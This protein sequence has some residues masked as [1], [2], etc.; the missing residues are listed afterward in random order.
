MRQPGLALASILLNRMG[1]ASQQEVSMPVSSRKNTSIYSPKEGKVQ[2]LTL[3]MSAGFIAGGLEGAL[4]GPVDR[5]KNRA[6]LL[7]RLPDQTYPSWLRQLAVPANNTWRDL[8]KGTSVYT[9]QKSL[10]KSV[11]FAVSYQ[12]REWFQNEMGCGKIMAGFLGGI[13]AGTAEVVF[14]Q[15]VDY[16]K[17]QLQSQGSLRSGFS[18]RSAYNGAMPTWCRNMLGSGIPFAA[19]AAVY[20]YF[21]SRVGENSLHDSIASAVTAFTRVFISHPMDLLKVLKQTNPDL[22]TQSMLTVLQSIY[23]RNGLPG[24]MQGFSV[25]LLGTGSKFFFA[26]M[27]YKVIIDQLTQWVM[28]T[29]EGVKSPQ[30]PIQEQ[31]LLL[32]HAADQHQPNDTEQSHHNAEQ[33]TPDVSS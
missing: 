2:S 10:Q 5:I 4:F 16:I 7:P 27:G 14:L 20:Q 3:K 17:V 31:N 9:L 22:A 18:L 24:L 6:L 13:S 28:P 11:V 33:S 8:W 29:A 15:P 12:A 25:K 32:Q 19:D 30:T 23:H 26:M 1:S 21:G